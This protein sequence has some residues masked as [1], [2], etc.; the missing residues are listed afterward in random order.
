M[1][2]GTSTSTDTLP[3]IESGMISQS[4]TRYSPSA[5]SPPPCQR[6]CQRP[7]IPALAVR[8]PKTSWSIT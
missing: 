3:L 7:A 8:H 6:G 2:A 5:S 4:G 1:V